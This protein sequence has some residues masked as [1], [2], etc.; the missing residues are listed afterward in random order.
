L[1][2]V[3]FALEE[4]VKSAPAASVR[5]G[6]VVALALEARDDDGGVVEHAPA[7]DPLIYLHGHGNIVPGLEEALEGRTQ[8]DRVQVAVPPEGAYGPRSGRSLITVDRAEL[9]ADVELEE[10]ME[11]EAEHDDGSFDVVWVREIKGDKVVIDTDHPLAGVTLRFDVEVL[12]IRDATAEEL[13]H[14]HPHIDEDSHHLH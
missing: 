12:S 8:G 3:P 2:G 13:E 14:G 1:L 7:S 11:L 10:G 5:E 4:S 6:T 9:P